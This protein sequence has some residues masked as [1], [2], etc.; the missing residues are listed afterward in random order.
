MVNVFPRPI[1]ADNP[2]KKGSVIIIDDEV[3][4][5]SALSEMLTKHGYTAQG[6]SKPNQAMETIQAR[7]F[8]IMLVD[9]M[10]PEIDGI[11]LIRQAH[12]LD[13]N[14]ICIMMTGQG[15]VQTAVEAMK[16]GAYDYILKPFKLTT[17]LTALN[18]SMEV[19]QLRNENDTL[20]E[21]VNI[22]EFG[23][24]VASTLDFD[25]ILEKTSQAILHQL[26]ADEVSILVPS[27]NETCYLIAA[28][29]EHDRV[30][31]IRGQTVAVEGSVT[32]WVVNH[33]RPLT[34]HGEMHDAR[35]TSTYPRP[36]IQSAF[37]FPMMA[38]KKLVGVLH[39]NDIHKYYELEEADLKLLSI[40][41]SIASS[42]LENAQLYEQTEKHLQRLSALRTIDL[43][44]TSS[45]DLRLTLNVLLE[46]VASQ[47]AAD[48]VA[49]RL[50]NNETHQLEFAAGK[51]F[52]THRL[53]SSLSLG[54]GL[55]GTAA[56]ERKAVI[57]TDLEAAKAGPMLNRLVSEEGIQ[58]Y[59]AAP[60]LA[61]GNL[62]GVLEVL[63][64]TTFEPD[65]EWLDY[66]EALAGQ[67]AIAINN[68]RLFD[69]LQLSNQQL[70][71]SYDATIEG[72]SR[73]LDLRD[74]ETEG[75]TQRVTEMTLRLARAMQEFNEEDILHIYRGAL[76][77]DIGKMGIP[78]YILLKP[79]KLSEEETRVM[80][81]HPQYAY[82]LLYP[83]PY[84][85]KSLDIPY[86]HHERWDGSGYPHGLREN[87]IPLA[88]R[89]FAVVDVWDALRSDRPYRPGWPDEQV[90][91]Y[92]H[93]E[94]GKLF[95]PNVVE[96]F[97]SLLNSSKPQ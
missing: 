9:L 59:F 11:T 5:V 26:D 77:H 67:A 84:L 16:S 19:R 37:S 40:I 41:V 73:A 1:Q 66:F 92:I 63:N 85:R 38:G 18:H 6:F 64:R 52:R 96:M 87:A 82:D 3:E 50:F 75:H 86:Y 71:V 56:L 23:Q 42:A 69:H 28:A 36:D 57:L 81:K 95:D 54:M 83:I 88:A 4:L 45:L 32:G 17:I 35:F 60:L 34:L 80:Q 25:V 31:E 65:A 79:G 21:I 90:V 27:P 10:M 68:A 47:L 43:A 20:R 12:E 24:M 93:N 29:Y 44:I 49:I 39:I 61:K 7:S 53:E 46:Q 91:E 2:A 58:A 94:A 14:M 48:A 72:W 13:P 89:I 74:Q 70:K 51:G 62:E 78:D 76:L 30:R 15:T 33:L 55:A 8:D 97:L 22:Y